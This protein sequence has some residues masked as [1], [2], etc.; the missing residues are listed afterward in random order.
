MM[1]CDA[2]KTSLG[3]VLM[4]NRQVMA[5]TSIQLRVHERNYSTYDLELE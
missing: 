5:Y 2:S 4:Q 3:G 1:Y